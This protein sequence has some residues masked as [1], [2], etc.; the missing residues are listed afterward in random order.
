[1]ADA[2]SEERG[3]GK[4]LTEKSA[5]DRLFRVVWSYLR[6]WLVLVAILLLAKAVGQVYGRISEWLES[7]SK[8]LGSPVPS[9]ALVLALLIIVP[10][11]LGKVVEILLVG[12]F[13]QRQR[14]MRAFQKLEWR[15]TSE[16]SPDESRGYRVA[17]INFPNSVTRSLGLIVAEL[18]E[19]GTGRKLAPV[20]LP[21]TPDPSKGAIHVV[22][23]DDLALTDWGLSDLTQFHLTFGAASHDLSDVDE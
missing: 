13:F 12:R 9:V 16:F 1:M 3:D 22:A 7:F 4:E 23:V 21:G 20:Y 10:W 5:R 2:Q 11:V 15:L 8:P 19:P 18:M 14:G 17:L 6:G